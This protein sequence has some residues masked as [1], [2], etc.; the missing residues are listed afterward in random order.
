[1][2]SLTK[3]REKVIRKE[4]QVKRKLRDLESRKKGG[5]FLWLNHLK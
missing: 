5:D 2:F 4:R 3:L 1:M